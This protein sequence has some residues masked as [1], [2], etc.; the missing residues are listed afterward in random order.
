MASLRVDAEMPGGLRLR[1]LIPADAELLVEATLEETG[2]AL[3]GPRPAGPYTLADA[4]D[5][6]RDWDPDR[7]E[8]V[9]FGIV[10]DDRLLAAFGLM[11]DS[12]DILRSGSEVL[13]S[14]SGPG[15][16]RESGPDLVRESGGVAELAYWV[17]PPHRR[18]GLASA[19]LRLL[20]AWSLASAGFRSLW[21]E[22]NPAN[23]ASLG[24]AEHAGYRFDRRIPG[25][26]RSWTTDD[27]AHDTRHDCLIWV[28]P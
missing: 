5:A 13:P 22:I 10:R 12:G 14:Q 19:G 1:T 11:P 26:C 3:W 25:H 20:T 8:Q 17:P 27:P 4:R 21:L 16:L 23:P 2:P 7:G 6:L 24:V 15:L 9:S 18:Q 28:N